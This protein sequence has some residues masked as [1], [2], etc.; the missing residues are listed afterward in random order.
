[1]PHDTAGLRDS[2]DR[3]DLDGMSRTRDVAEEADIILYLQPAKDGGPGLPISD[4]MAGKV[5]TR[6]IT[7]LTK[8]DPVETPSRD[9][10]GVAGSGRSVRTST[11][12]G[13][14]L[15]DLWIALHEITA[16][17]RLDEA[18]AR[19]VVLNDRHRGRLSACREGLGELADLVRQDGIG[20]E[21][22]A[23]LLAGLVASVGEVS[24]RVFSEQVLASVFA[25]FC[26]GK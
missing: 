24:G 15:A 12:T 4:A 6:G 23:T 1:M 10:S 3:I 14:G 9:E 25:R 2:G 17:F 19:G 21:V 13:E 26:V 18:V 20:A 8:C 5:S 16:C 11:V 7:V 22:V